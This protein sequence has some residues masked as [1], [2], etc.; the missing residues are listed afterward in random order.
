M[1]SELKGPIL[2]YV[3]NE[4][5][6]TNPISGSVGRKSFDIKLHPHEIRV[7]TFKDPRPSH[8]YYGKFIEV[9]AGSED[10]AS[11]YIGDNARIRATY[12]TPQVKMNKL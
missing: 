6:K 1:R 12:T 11:W 5:N 9:N 2:V 8:L 4:T 7:L 3:K 10:S